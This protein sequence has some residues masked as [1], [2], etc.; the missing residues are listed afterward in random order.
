MH[1]GDN[2]CIWMGFQGIFQLLRINRATPVILHHHRD[3]AAALYVFL[4]APAK[5]A[6]LADDDFISRFDQVDEA[7]FH[8]R[9]TRR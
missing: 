6:V 5:H 1:E 3:A 7:G 9:R 2:L 8:A 4:H